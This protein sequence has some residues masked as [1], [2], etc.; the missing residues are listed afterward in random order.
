VR[1]HRT[2]KIRQFITWVLSVAIITI[3]LFPVA[4]TFLTSIKDPAEIF[5][6]PPSLLSENPTLVNY[7][8]VLT[9]TAIPKQLINSIFVAIAAILITIIASSLAGYSL[10]R[11]R[12]KGKNALSLA[13]LAIHMVSGI[14]NVI[15]LY[16]IA[17]Q[18]RLL[19]SL[20]FLALI[21]ASA[22]TPFS[23]WFM[24]GYF[25]KIPTE[26]EDAAMVDGCSRWQSFF[27]I[28]IPLAAPALVTVSLY[29]F[30]IAWNEFIIASILLSSETKKTLPLGI[31]SFVTFHGGFEWGYITATAI[32]GVLPVLVL[33]LSLQKYFLAGLMGGSLKE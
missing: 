29:S 7:I 10:A 17:Y 15:A 31:Y 13:I 23:V 3:M 2:E 28:S 32:I 26:L 4:W 5:D 19:D 27:R 20:P 22:A 1:R 18:L 30:A 14:G 24:R 21:Y 9:Q 6:Y 16:I 25:E 11:S 8:Y 12:L 33:F